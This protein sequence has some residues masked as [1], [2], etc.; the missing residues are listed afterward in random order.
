[1]IVLPAQASIELAKTPQTQVITGGGTAT[2]RITVTNTGDVPLTAVQVAD[3]TTPDCARTGAANLGTLAPGQSVSYVCTQPNVTANFTNVATATGQP[4]SGPTVSAT[5]TALVEVVPPEVAGIEV[6]PDHPSIQVAKT[7]QR[8]VAVGGTATFRITVINTG[9]VPLTAVQVTDAAAPGCARTG[10]A[11]LGALAP[12]Q[13][14]SYVC[15]QPNVTASF[16]NVATATG[17]PPSGPPV[18]ATDDA[19]VVAARLPATGARPA[20]AGQAP[21]GRA[22]PL[23]GPFGALLLVAAGGGL[24]LWRLTSRRR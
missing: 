13:S 4:P 10:A 20:P 14:V 15:T 5:A 21:G 1:V 11:N 2:F 16:T 23:A 7:P 22:A 3:A 18:T 24:S 8:Q 12:G 17:Q 9:D 6:A 19:E